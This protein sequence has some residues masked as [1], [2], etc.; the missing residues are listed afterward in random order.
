MSCLL[1]FA[2]TFLELLNGVDLEIF[3]K[4]KAMFTIVSGVSSSLDD[5]ENSV[6]IFLDLSKPFD[7]N[8]N[9]LLKKLSRKI[10]VSEGLRVIGFHHTF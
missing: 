5:R 8:H 3:C 1:Y 6:G 4:Y 2:D 10:M 9:T 7:V